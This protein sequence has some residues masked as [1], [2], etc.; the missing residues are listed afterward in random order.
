MLKSQGRLARDGG[1]EEGMDMF[2]QLVRER[3]PH[4]VHVRYH[5][6]DALAVAIV[7]LGE[8]FD[9]AASGLHARES[10]RVVAHRVCYWIFW[11]ATIVPLLLLLVSTL[12]KQRLTH[13]GFC[14]GV[15]TLCVFFALVCA[16]TGLNVVAYFL[17]LYSATSDKFLFVFVLA[18]AVCSVAAYLLMAQQSMWSRKAPK[19]STTKVDSMMIASKLHL[20][21][22]LGHHSGSSST[23]S[24]SSQDA[25]VESSS[26]SVSAYE[27]PV[28]E[29][30]SAVIF[31]PRGPRTR[32]VP[33]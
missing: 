18:T 11:H 20:T 31:R 15:Y 29:T 30:R 12:T 21:F 5:Y 26:S 22:D 7:P 28:G 25:H 9:S 17:R 27:E 3:L 4:A 6:R 13:D 33:F 14:D 16:A 23:S 19:F 10:L 1:R 8:A 32:T 2:D 24:S